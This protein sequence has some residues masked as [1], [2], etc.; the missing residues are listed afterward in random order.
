[1]ETLSFSKNLWI[2]K[3]PYLKIYIFCPASA[4]NENKKGKSIEPVT[5]FKAKTFLLPPPSHQRIPL[6]QVK[7]FSQPISRSLKNSSKWTIFQLPVPGVYV[8]SS[9]RTFWNHLRTLRTRCVVKNTWPL[10]PRVVMGVS[11]LSNFQW[12]CVSTLGCIYI[13]ISLFIVLLR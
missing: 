5:F 6:F 2:P 11:A 1:M 8:F 13:I 9:F 12:R 10:G 3:I 4:P 7:W